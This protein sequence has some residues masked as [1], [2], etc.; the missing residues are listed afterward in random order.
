LENGTSD[1]QEGDGHSS[2]CLW[3]GHDLIIELAEEEDYITDEQKYF[4]SYNNHIIKMTLVLKYVS[5]YTEVLLLFMINFMSWWLGKRWKSYGAIPGIVSMINWACN[6]CT[7]F[8]S[9]A[10]NNHLCRR[11]PLRH[12]GWLAFALHRKTRLVSPWA[13]SCIKK[14]DV[15]WIIAHIG[16]SGRKCERVR[17]I[18]KVKVSRSSSWPLLWEPLILQEK[19][20]YLRL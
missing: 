13:S 12:T 5:E 17:E 16:D 18:K 15:G 8:S 11:H 19:H 7:N 9:M 3:T 2:F 1:V 10:G 20:H 6:S 14:T 4:I